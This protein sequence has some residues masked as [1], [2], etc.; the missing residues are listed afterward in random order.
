MAAKKTI[1]AKKKTAVKGGVA[2][3]IVK[4]HSENVKLEAIGL[5][6][7]GH[8]YTFVA[9]KL[10]ISVGTAKTWK[11]N[12][13]PSITAEMRKDWAEQIEYNL[14]RTII[15]AQHAMMEQLEVMSDSEWIRKQT[16]SDL[17]VLHGVTHDKVVRLLEATG[18]GQDADEGRG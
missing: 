1:A 15:M 6:M 10:G 3:K 14:Y 8:S 18:Q 16:A 9:N 5:Y 13:M 11:H 17:A 4:Q 12:I 7:Q 2:V